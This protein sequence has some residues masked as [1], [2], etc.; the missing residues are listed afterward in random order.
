MAADLD[1]NNNLDQADLQ[2]LRRLLLEPGLQFPDSCSNWIFWPQSY[3]FS[4]PDEPFGHPSSIT[5]E[6]IQR[7]T[8][9]I[10]FYGIKRGD[11]GSNASPLQNSITTDTL[12]FLLENAPAN[13]GDTLHATFHTQN[14][15]QL[16]G[17]QFELQFDT[18]ALSFAGLELGTVPSLTEEHFGLSMVDTGLIRVVWLD[19]LGNAQ[20]MADLEQAFTLTFVA[21]NNILDRRNHIG[22]NDRNLAAAAFDASLL[23]TAV[24]LKFDQVSSLNGH[25]TITFSLLQNRP[26]PFTDQTIIPFELPNSARAT[27]RIYNQLGQEVWRKTAQ[28][29]AG[30]SQE[31]LR[32]TAAGL[33]YYS[34]ETP[35]GSATKRMVL[36]RE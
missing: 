16:V 25:P 15:E 26:N 4:D 5:I 24:S 29:P 30:Q 3:T 17:F 10:D 2:L 7:D 32:L 36:T 8:S 12:F 31:E 18:A 20:E 14:F 13:T 35:W 19:I 27:L 6:S 9:G 33:Y 22:I 21:R 23:E 1:C 34:L 28:Y 11:L